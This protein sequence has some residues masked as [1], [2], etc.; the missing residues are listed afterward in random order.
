MAAALGRGAR[1]ALLA[2][3]LG[4]HVGR[5]AARQV[6]QRVGAERAG[7]RRVGQQRADRQQLVPAQRLQRRADLARRGLPPGLGAPAHRPLD[8]LQLQLRH[9]GAPCDDGRVQSRLEPRRARRGCPWRP[10]V[11]DSRPCRPSRTR[12][13][14]AVPGAV[15]YLRWILFAILLVAS[16]AALIGLPRAEAGGWST[17]LRLVPVLLLVLF[18]GGY[19]TYRFTL[20]RA[21]H[22]PAGKALV[23]V[24][25]LVL[26][27]LAITG[28]ALDR[29][30]PRQPG[31]RP[32]PGRAARQP[33][34]AWLRAVASEVVRHRPR[35]RGAGPRP[36]ADRAARRRVAAGPARGPR[37]AGGA[38]RPRRGRGARRR[39]S[40][41]RGSGAPAA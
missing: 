17:W 26:L 35:R 12:A 29:P 41:A 22:Y 11:V 28:I 37:H 21:G 4:G 13:T 8:G 27:T 32:R 39:R 23:R 3:P 36:A 33:R 18:I 15:P 6:G 16:S 34:A 5:H 25:M 14:T 2:L 20:V 31:A 30:P 40:L 7:R 19:A 9:G 1:V 10:R 38:G 24:A